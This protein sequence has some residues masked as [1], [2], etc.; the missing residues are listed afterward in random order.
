MF[1]PSSGNVLYDFCYDQYGVVQS[2]CA[3]SISANYYYGTNAHTHSS[4]APPLST[5]TPSSGYTN[6]S[7]YLQVTLATA[8]V[9][10]AEDL[11]SC[12]YYTCSYF[13]YA[14]GVAG[15]YWVAPLGVWIQN[16]AKPIHGNSVSYNHWMTTNAG[17]GIYNTT[18]AYEVDYPGLVYSNDMSLA[19]GGKFDIN[20]DWASPHIN[21]DDGTAADIDYIPSGNVSDFLGYCEHFGAVDYR[22]EANGS[23]HCRW[24]Y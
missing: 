1:A 21:H 4:P 11:E 6:S 20:A 22:L 8:I 19:F 12:T 16:G 14:V 5:V 15:I 10:H 2:N 3:I 7:G 23:I 13:Q 24:A 18:V 9:G 17:T